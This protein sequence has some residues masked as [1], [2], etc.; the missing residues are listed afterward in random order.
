AAE[1]QRRREAPGDRG[2]PEA[3]AGR[4]PRLLRGPAHGAARAR[5]APD[6]ADPRRASAGAGRPRAPALPP[7]GPDTG[8]EHRSARRGAAGRAALTRS[9]PPPQELRLT[10]TIVASSSH[11]RPSPHASAA[12]KSFARIVS[13]GWAWCWRTAARTRSTPKNSPALSRRSR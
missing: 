10:T 9:A 5:R 7:R 3:L 11:G 6:E 12:S 8:R 4:L 1:P 13:A 2:V